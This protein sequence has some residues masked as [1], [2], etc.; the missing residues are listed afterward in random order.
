MGPVRLAEPP[1]CGWPPAALLIWVES[2]AA[3]A[4]ERVP[5]RSPRV[6]S[7]CSMARQRGSRPFIMA[8]IGEAMKI[9][10]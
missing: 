4:G 3:A 9:D 10:E 8:R 5:T 1:P 2:A 7:R 6:V